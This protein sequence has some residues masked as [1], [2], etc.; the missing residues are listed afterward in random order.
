MNGSRW[1]GPFLFG[2]A[3]ICIIPSIR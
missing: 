2:K 3:L 1:C